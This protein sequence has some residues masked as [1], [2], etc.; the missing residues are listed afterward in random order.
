MHRVV[1]GPQWWGFESFIEFKGQ[2]AGKGW[3]VHIF[4]GPQFLKDP[5]CSSLKV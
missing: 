3:W 5:L 2:D 1:A 4:S